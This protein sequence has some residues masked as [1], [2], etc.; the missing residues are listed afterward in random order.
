MAL[1]EFVTKKPRRLAMDTAARLTLSHFVGGQMVE[2]GGD[3]FGDIYNPA[4]GEVTKQVPLATTEEVRSAV[5]FLNR[6]VQSLSVG[7]QPA[8]QCRRI[9]Q[10]QQRRK[11]IPDRSKKFYTAVRTN[12]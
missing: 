11:D 1:S 12:Q 5:V 8:S 6:K 2:G 4:T 10:R 9:G 3:R 7:H